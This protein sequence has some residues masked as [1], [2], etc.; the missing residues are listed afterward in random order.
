MSTEPLQ[1]CKISSHTAFRLIK[2]GRWVRQK[3]CGVHIYCVRREVNPCKDE[4]LKPGLLLWTFRL[5]LIDMSPLS[6]MFK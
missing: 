4:Y 3:L 2:G 6:H 5:H 1:A